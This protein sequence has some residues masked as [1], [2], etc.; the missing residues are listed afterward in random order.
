MIIEYISIYAC[1]R[2]TFTY[3]IDM[4]RHIDSHVQWL[5]QHT[6]NKLGRGLVST[7]PG[8]HAS[9]RS[10]CLC[11]WIFMYINVMRAT[12]FSTHLSTFFSWIVLVPMC[13]RSLFQEGH[14]QTVVEWKARNSG[15]LKSSYNSSWRRY[16]QVLSH[17]LGHPRDKHILKKC[18]FSTLKGPSTA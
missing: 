5:L 11:Q 9:V 8:A 15:Y 12:F 17:T 14:I 13:Q 10:M 7:S 16:H 1:I 2:N 3:Y 4:Y 18:I 6:A